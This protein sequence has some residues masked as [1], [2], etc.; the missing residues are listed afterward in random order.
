MEFINF[1]K[2]K[3]EMKITFALIIFFISIFSIIAEF[4]YHF[5]RYKRVYDSL[6][7]Y[8]F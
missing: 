6:I 7:K 5:I 3:I 8:I 2:F 1:I 4:L